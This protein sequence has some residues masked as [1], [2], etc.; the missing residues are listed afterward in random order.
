ML[1]VGCGCIVVPFSSSFFTAIAL[2]DL[3]GEQIPMETISG[4]SRMIIIQFG[5]ANPGRACHA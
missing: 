3:V 2:L 5:I 4:K 1:E